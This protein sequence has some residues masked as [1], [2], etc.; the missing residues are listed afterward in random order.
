MSRTS[1]STSG[2]VFRTGS[3][4]SN[5]IPSNDA[6]FDDARPTHKPRAFTL[7]V[8]HARLCV[9]A[10]SGARTAEGVGAWDRQQALVILFS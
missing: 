6:S 8:V 7:V 5:T 4:Q 2:N 3:N 9:H 1:L 10:A